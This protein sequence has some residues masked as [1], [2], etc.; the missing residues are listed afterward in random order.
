M[1]RN[2][3]KSLARASLAG[4]TG[5]DALRLTYGAAENFQ[6]LGEQT[7]MTS[8]QPGNTQLTTVW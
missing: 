8:V 2:P 6:F 3:G 5:S 1:G 4:V 7:A